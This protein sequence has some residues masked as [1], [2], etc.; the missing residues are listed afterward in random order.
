[1]SP[2]IQRAERSIQRRASGWSAIE[3]GGT[4]RAIASRTDCTSAGHSASQ[5][6]HRSTTSLSSAALK[7]CSKVDIIDRLASQSS[8]GG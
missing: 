8:I 2:F 7:Y 1:M 6:F 4:P 5:C 3:S